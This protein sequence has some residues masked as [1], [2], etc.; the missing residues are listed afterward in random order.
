MVTPDNKIVDI[1]AKEDEIDWKEVGKALG[2][3]ACIGLALGALL[4]IR[5]TKIQ[6]IHVL[7]PADVYNQMWRDMQEFE[8]PMPWMSTLLR[9]TIMLPV[10]PAA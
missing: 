5:Y 7:P 9:G 1:P 4:A 6:T 8:G 2:A 10:D 3:G